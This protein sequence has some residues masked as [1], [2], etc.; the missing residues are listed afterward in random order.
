MEYHIFQV[1]GLMFQE[2]LNLNE[3]C[4]LKQKQVEEFVLESFMEM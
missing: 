3:H 4:Y 2:M 1:F